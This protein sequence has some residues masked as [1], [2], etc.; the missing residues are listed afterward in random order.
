MDKEVAG[1]KP[2]IHVMNVFEEKGLKV[3]DSKK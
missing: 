3:D 1:R 2:L